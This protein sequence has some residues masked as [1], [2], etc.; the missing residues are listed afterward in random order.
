MGVRCAYIV[1]DNSDK[2]A[3][4]KN[5]G[6]G[7]PHDPTASSAQRLS[8]S[9]CACV[10]VCLCFLFGCVFCVRLV[11]VGVREWP[12]LPRVGEVESMLQSHTRH[13][14]QGH[15]IRLTLHHTQAKHGLARHIKTG[16]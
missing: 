4:Y 7:L 1:L 13:S 5:S 10:C 15:L 16:K 2:N 8:V 6:I 3:L 14:L 11:G 12:H 9:V